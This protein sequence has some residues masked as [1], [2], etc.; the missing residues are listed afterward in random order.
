MLVFYCGEDEVT[1]LIAKQLTRFCWTSISDEAIEFE[2]ANPKD[3]GTKA[4]ESLPKLVN[5]GMSYPSIGVFDSDGDCILAFLQK[6]TPSGWTIQYG[7]INIANDEAEVWLL[8]DSIGFAK[9]LDVDLSVLPQKAEHADEIVVP[10]KTSQF[11]VNEIAPLSSSQNVLN[12]FYTPNKNRKP[13][14]YNNLWPDFI[15]YHWD[16]NRAMANSVTLTRAVV[17]ITDALIRYKDNRQV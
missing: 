17:R 3:R 14:T 15:E 13:A 9:C 10:Y 2:D 12:T 7:A 1:K 6:Y 8:A 11:I 4:L 5:L 16:I